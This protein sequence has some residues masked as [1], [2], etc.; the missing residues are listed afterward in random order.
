MSLIATPIECAAPTGLLLPGF[1]KRALILTEPWV[2]DAWE[3]WGGDHAETPLELEIRV[4]AYDEVPER[5]RTILRP[6][7]WRGNKAHWP[8]KGGEP[9]GITLPAGT[10][11]GIWIV[12]SKTDY[13]LL[14]LLR[15]GPQRPELVLLHPSRVPLPGEGETVG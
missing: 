6:A 4:G 15:R 2:L 13:F 7:I 5:M 9:L 14:N 8:T 10:F 12:E 11:L 3:L 1:A